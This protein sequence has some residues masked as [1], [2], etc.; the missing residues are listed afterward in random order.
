VNFG[1]DPGTLP[2]SGFQVG[3]PVMLLEQ[4][5]KRLIRELLEIHHPVTSQKIERHPGFIVKLDS[6]AKHAGPPHQSLAC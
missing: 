6:L 4:I 2:Q 3:W 5:A 1:A